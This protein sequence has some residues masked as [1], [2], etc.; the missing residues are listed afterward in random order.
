MCPH[1]PHAGLA[2]NICSLCVC[3]TMHHTPDLLAGFVSGIA[4]SLVKQVV[5][6][7]VDTVKV[8]LQTTPLEPGQTV[9][10]RAGLFKDLYRGILVPLV[11]NA[12]AGG[13]FFAAKDAVKSSL[14]TLGNVPSTLAAIL[15]AQFPYWLVRQPSEVLKVRRQAVGQPPS[16]SQSVD[17][18]ALRELLGELDVRR[19]GAVENLFQ[20]FG[21][22]L[23]YTF[24][25][26]QSASA[27]SYGTWL[28]QVWNA[29]NCCV[30]GG[31]LSGLD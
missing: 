16:A 17:R 12:P 2:H 11:F 29:A 27:I 23:A 28:R 5:L 7:P 19:P 20:G 26:T 21:S 8:R 25:G 13:V 15:V 18:K 31:L 30:R 6:Y 24:P 3:V 22:N 10:T 14:A 9:W 1:N 4:V